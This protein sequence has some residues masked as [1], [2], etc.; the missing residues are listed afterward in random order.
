MQIVLDRIRH[1]VPE[2]IAKSIHYKKNPYTM[3]W[4]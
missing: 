3:T 4:Q 2:D 1:Y